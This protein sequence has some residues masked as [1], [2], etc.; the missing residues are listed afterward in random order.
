MN[1]TSCL[2]QTQDVVGRESSRGD[3]IQTVGTAGFP[4]RRS[5]SSRRVPLED[6]PDAGQALG[7]PRS[8]R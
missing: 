4:D 2:G 3:D 7:P 6:E 5:V 1:T 8:S